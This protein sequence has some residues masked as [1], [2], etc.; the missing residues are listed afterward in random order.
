[1]EP[2]SVYD[3]FLVRFKKDLWNKCVEYKV[4]D[5]IGQE[6]LE[7]TKKVFENIV[8]NY[9]TQILQ[10]EGQEN[11]SVLYDKLINEISLELTPLKKITRDSIQKDK[12]E[13]FDKQ[14]VEKQNEFNTMMKKDVPPSPQFKDENK[15][16]PIDQKN[17]DELIEKQMKEREKVMNINEQIT[18]PQNTI[19]EQNHII[20][21]REYN[22]PENS[23]MESPRIYNE[24][25]QKIEQRI[26]VQ[27]MILQ[28][29]LESQLTILKK[30]K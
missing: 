17:L 14:L 29:I 4:F 18:E 12:Q 24:Q 2:S 3:T 13:L 21:T 19:I 7:N 25:L 10:H 9:Q 6:H 26:Q 22:L 5:Y 30:L 28:Q 1:M 15:D 27:T 11:T 8:S 20:E 16:D 23:P